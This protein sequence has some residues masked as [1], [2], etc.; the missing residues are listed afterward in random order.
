MAKHQKAATSRRTPKSLS[1]WAKSSTSVPFSIIDLHDTCIGAKIC[2]VI[3][4]DAFPTQTGRHRCHFLL[5]LSTSLPFFLCTLACIG[6]FF[7]HVSIML[8]FDTE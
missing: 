1:V 3:C 2:E 4:I 7:H 5:A 8:H 6:A